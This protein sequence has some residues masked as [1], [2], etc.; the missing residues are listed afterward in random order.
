[1][2]PTY[3]G[4]DK[5]PM[6]FDEEQRGSG[7]SFYTNP[8]YDSDATMGPSGRDSMGASVKILCLHGGGGSAS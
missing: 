6:M 3:D 1:M 7:G 8:T 5:S 2:K 4:T